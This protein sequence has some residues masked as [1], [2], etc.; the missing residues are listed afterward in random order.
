MRAFDIVLFGATGF[1]GRLVAEYLVRKG[2]G[3]KIAFAGRNRGK[4][5]AL[6]TEIGADVPVLLADVSEPSSLLDLARRTKVICTTVGPYATYGGPL[7]RACAESGTDYCDLAGEVQ[8]IRRM[9]DAHE[10]AAKRS[11]ARIVTSCGFDSIPSDLGVHVLQAHATAR[12][13]AP[14]EHV[15]FAVTKMRGGAS[16]GT[17]ASML[18]VIEEAVRDSEVRAILKDPYALNPEGER[19]GAEDG[20]IRGVA[21]DP[22]LGA[23]TAPFVMGAINERV[24][25]RTNAISGYPYGRNFRYHEVMAFRKGPRGFARAAG[26]TA[27]L[28]SLFAGAAITPVRFLLE[29]TM[30]PSPGEGPSAEQRA[31]GFFEISLV[32]KGT[33]ADGR[34]FLIRGAVSG[35]GDPGYAATSRM[36]GES[37]LCL[38]LDPRKTDGGLLTPAAALGD[39]LVTRLAGAGVTFRAG[40]TARD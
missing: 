18:G 16:G 12:H 22:D 11:G 15:I 37:A 35:N 25:R 26:L 6:R 34:P 8:W 7:V 28:A 31:R 38:A 39:Q 21:W 20:R 1:T 27:G 5:E 3:A 30:M 17:I 29:K 24:V 40:E 14:A 19:N 10:E 9:I 2:Q 4:L 33:A 32:G 23:W 13:G 36:L